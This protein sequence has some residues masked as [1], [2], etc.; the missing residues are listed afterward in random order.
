M[1]DG[2]RVELPVRMRRRRERGQSAAGRRERRRARRRRLRADSRGVRPCAHDDVA[3]AVDPRAVRLGEHP[4]R[5]RSGSAQVRDVDRRDLERVVREAGDSHGLEPRSRAQVRLLLVPARD[6]HVRRRLRHGSPV[7]RDDEEA[8]AHG[9]RREI[10]VARCQGDRLRA[11]P[12]SKGFERARARD[13]RSDEA[14]PQPATKKTPAIARTRAR[15]T[16]PSL[17][18]ACRPQFRRISCRRSNRGSS[19]RARGTSPGR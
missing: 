19:R 10:R 17:V 14:D 13:V 12:R 8:E 1:R 16:L 5:P 18:T 15:R 3:D 7:V 9:T 2:R 11:L 6:P 4:V